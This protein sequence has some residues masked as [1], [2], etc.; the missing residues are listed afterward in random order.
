MFGGRWR[1]VRVSKAESAFGGCEQK[2]VSFE[3]LAGWSKNHSVANL[4]CPG[5]ADGASTDVETRDVA[6][7]NLAKHAGSTAC[8]DCRFATMTAPEYADYR[9]GQAEQETAAQQRIT[10]ALALRARQLKL[11][12]E[13]QAR[14]DAMQ[15]EDQ[16]AQLSPADAPPVFPSVPP[17]TEL[18]PA[19]N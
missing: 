17:T 11:Q 13:I 4:E 10:D 18:P 1:W 14:I 2:K 9:A 8:I 15:S 16:A 6:L 5:G 3:N 12:A 19:A 7:K